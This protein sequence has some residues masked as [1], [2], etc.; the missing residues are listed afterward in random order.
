[1][2]MEKSWSMDLFWFCSNW[3]LCWQVFR[4]MFRTTVNGNIENAVW[5][6]MI[7]LTLSFFLCYGTI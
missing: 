2:L 6:E 7:K 5:A 3:Q 1:M 4:M